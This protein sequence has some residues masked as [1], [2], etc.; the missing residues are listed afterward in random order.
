MP[1]IDPRNRRLYTSYDELPPY[2]LEQI[3]KIFRN[4]YIRLLRIEG[5]R[6]RNPLRDR[7]EVADRFRSGVYRH[8]VRT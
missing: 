6:G 7:G 3:E 8:L 1:S 2:D 5:G 4:M